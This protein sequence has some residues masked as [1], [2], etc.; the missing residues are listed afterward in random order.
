MTKNPNQSATQFRGGHGDLEQPGGLRGLHAVP[1]AG[2]GFGH[3]MQSTKSAGDFF[4]FLE[5]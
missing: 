2:C 1:G 3:R 5:L 4:S